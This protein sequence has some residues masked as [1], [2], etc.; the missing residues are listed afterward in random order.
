M[1]AS[2]KTAKDT[3]ETMTMAGAASAKE[4]MDRSM[5]AFAEASSFG[6]ENM[7][8]FVAAA[9]ATAKGFETLNARALAFA[10]ANMEHTMSAARSLSTVKSFQELLERQ[11]E[12]AR[13]SSDAY[14]AELNG[15]TEVLTATQKAATQPLTERVT[16]VMAKVPTR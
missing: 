9:T 11:T 16:A 2:R 4:Q 5:A 6:K 3:V 15:M 7:D 12:L 8:A 10:K 1:T 14:L 13:A